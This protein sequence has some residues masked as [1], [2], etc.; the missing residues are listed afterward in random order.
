MGGVCLVSLFSGT[1]Y[2]REREDCRIE[3]IP[4]IF[5]LIRVSHHVNFFHPQIKL[6]PS[7]RP[8][9]CSFRFPVF[10]NNFFEQFFW[11][12]DPKRQKLFLKICPHHMLEFRKKSDIFCS[13]AE[14]WRAKFRRNYGKRSNCS[15]W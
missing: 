7:Q 13:Y 5:S 8:L 11:R 6:L 15:T 12:H 4:I 3:K 1:R 2:I 14:K 10:P 9:A